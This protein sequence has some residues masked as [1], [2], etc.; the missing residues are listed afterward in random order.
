M[1]MPA[2][3]DAVRS[4]VCGASSC[5]RVLELRGDAERRFAYAILP[6]LRDFYANRPEEAL[7]R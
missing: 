3:R 2:L 6:A 5:C 7:R 4:A 1:T